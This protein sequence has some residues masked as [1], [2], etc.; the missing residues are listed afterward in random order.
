MV[1]GIDDL[2]YFV[3]SLNFGGS[4]LLVEIV[5]YD[6]VGLLFGNGA[7]NIVF[8]DESCSIDVMI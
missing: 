2:D 1:Y 3:L 5:E 4:V 6:V 8:I 7:E